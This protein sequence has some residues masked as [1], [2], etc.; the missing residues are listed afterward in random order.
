MTAHT[1]VDDV[2]VAL[3][4][5]AL[6]RQRTMRRQLQQATSLTV[7]LADEEIVVSLIRRPWCFGGQRLDAVCPGCN[8]A[9]GVLRLAPA[10]AATRLACRRCL[11]KL[12]VRYRS[13]MRRSRKA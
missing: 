10:G 9:V 4:L 12:K 3:D 6:R 5:T 1:F 7:V 11:E 13:Q 8:S 2:E